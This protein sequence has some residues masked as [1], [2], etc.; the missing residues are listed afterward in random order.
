VSDALWH[1]YRDR[2][3]LVTGGTRG[4]GLATALAFGRRGAQVTVTYKWG[5]ADESELR[6]RFAAVGAPPPVIARADASSEDDVRMVLED[7][8]ARHGH[9]EVLVSN[10]AFAAL[11]RSVDEYVHRALITSINYT[12]WPIVSH[13]LAARAVCGRPPRYIVGVSSTGID[14][15]LMHYDFVAASKAVLESLCRYLHYRLR[16]EGSS[17]NVVRTRFVDTDSLAATAGDEFA[18]F[19][20][21]YEP[22][23]ISTPEEVAEAIFGVCSGLLDAL[24]GQVLTVDRGAGSYD[25]FSRLYTERDHHPICPKENPR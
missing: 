20:R 4:I 18:P 11:V 1:D 3:V 14:S 13:T 2:A 16:E 7:I 24:G 25:N 23:V 15:M 6:D 10:V 9:L 19:L 8:R 12:A 21:R 17:V 5:S 22:D